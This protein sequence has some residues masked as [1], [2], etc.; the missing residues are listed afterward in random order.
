MT[1][2]ALEARHISKMYRVYD[3]P[4]ARLKEILAFNRTPR[5]REFWAL[6][7]VSFAV[8]RGG[9]LGIIGVNGSGKST[10]LEIA[11]GTLEPTKGELIRHGKTAALLALGAGFNPEF[12]GREN[13]FLSGE[14]LG[15]SNAEVQQALPDIERFAEI[16]TFI[17]QPV[18]TY[19]TGMFLRLA[20]SVAIHVN[21]E[22]L[23]VDEVLAVGDAVFV[24][25]CIRKFDELRQRGVTVLLVSHDL[26]LV[27]QLCDRAILLSRGKVMAEG[28]PSDVVNRYNGLVLERQQQFLAHQSKQGV[29]P[30]T[31]TNPGMPA[32]Y[33]YRHGDGLAAVTGVQL[34][35]ENGGPVSAVRSGEI[36]TVR[37]IA[38]FAAAHPRPVIGIMLRTRIGTE[39]YGTNTLL[40]DTGPGPMEAGESCE[41]LFTFSCRLIPQEY[42]LTVAMQAAD[43]SSHDWVDDV[44]T[45]QV[46]DSPRRAGIANL[47]AT[48]S[49][50]KLRAANSVA[51]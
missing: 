15:L 41:V 39:V 17:D 43:G 3:S 40:E 29:V 24:N 32:G 6:D 8:P 16:G 30:E 20:F 23:I 10:L 2:I 38:S 1:I 22:I 7:D 45:F 49:S 47:E 9:A 51:R 31:G 46:I 28:T 35:G 44:L 48:V 50:R 26:A 12:S 34:L 19:S 18:K 5:H 33:S 11:A 21:P 27:K 36:V 14:I 37:I 13:V 42:T 4:A 25:R